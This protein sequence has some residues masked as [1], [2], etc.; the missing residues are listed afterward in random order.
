MYTDRYDEFVNGVHSRIASVL[1]G[2]CAPSDRAESKQV[3]MFSPLALEW[4]N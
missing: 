3:L 2:H 1:L 4:P